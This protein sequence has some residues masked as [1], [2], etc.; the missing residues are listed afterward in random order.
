MSIDIDYAQEM[1]ENISKIIEQ[2][3]ENDKDY[4]VEKKALDIMRVLEHVLAYTLY[5][6]CDDSDS[7]RD[8]AEQSYLNIRGQ[9]LRILNENPRD[10]EVL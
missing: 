5:T 4:T 7:I 8:S 1:V 2:T 3:G 10:T 6:T 9:A